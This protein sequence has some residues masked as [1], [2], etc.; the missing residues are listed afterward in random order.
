MN[1]NKSRTSPPALDTLKG[2]HDQWKPFSP[3][4][5]DPPTAGL[6]RRAPAF[7]P[8]GTTA[9]RDGV[10]TPILSGITIPEDED[11]DEDDNNIIPPRSHAFRVVNP[12]L[13]ERLSLFA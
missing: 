11:E 1:L 2:S 3:P 9:W 6:A 12:R 7:V 5:A 4:K 13:R 10:D 8:K